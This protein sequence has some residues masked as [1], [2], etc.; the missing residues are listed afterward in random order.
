MRNFGKPGNPRVHR[1][2][3]DRDCPRH[4][5]KLK[6]GVANVFGQASVLNVGGKHAHPVLFGHKVFERLVVAQ[7]NRVVVGIFFDFVKQFAKRAGRGIQSG[8]TKL[9]LGGFQRVVAQTEV[10]HMK[11]F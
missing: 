2:R 6:K 4:E 11:R 8:K 7:Q 10:E 9:Y 5:Q 3:F 1:E